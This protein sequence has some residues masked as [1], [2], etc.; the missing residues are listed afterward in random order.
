MFEVLLHIEQ[1][2]TP[3]PERWTFNEKLS[4]NATK[5]GVRRRIDESSPVEHID[6]RDNVDVAEDATYRFGVHNDEIGAPNLDDQEVEPANDEQAHEPK[7]KNGAVWK[8]QERK[9]SSH[10]SRSEKTA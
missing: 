3:P 5:D 7:A 10:C 1:L 9:S 4:Q 6:E 8:L 2:S